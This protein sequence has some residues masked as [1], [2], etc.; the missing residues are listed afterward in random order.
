MKKMIKNQINRQ[1][2]EGINACR[3]RINPYMQFRN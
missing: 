2:L 1:N 3:L